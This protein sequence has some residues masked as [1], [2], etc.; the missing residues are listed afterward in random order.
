M[1][2]GKRTILKNSKTRVSLFFRKEVLPTVLVKSRA[3]AFDHLLHGKG[4][5]PSATVQ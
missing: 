2:F 3:H 1:D 5:A 4:I